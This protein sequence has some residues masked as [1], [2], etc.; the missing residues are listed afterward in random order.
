MDKHESR[1]A[2][3]K[4]VSHTMGFVEGIECTKEIIT[5][6]LID[7]IQNGIIII[8]KGSDKLFEIINSVGRT[9]K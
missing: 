9:D 6:E 4:N 3:E 2:R 7:A 5:N 8:D 1:L